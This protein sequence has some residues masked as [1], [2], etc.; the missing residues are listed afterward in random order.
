M[1]TLIKLNGDFMDYKLA[2]V[3]QDIPNTCFN[4]LYGLGFM[5]AG[6]AITYAVDKLA[7]KAFNIQKGS[8]AS[9]AVKAGAFLAGVAV[10]AIA[11]P[12]AGIAAFTGKKVLEMVVLNIVSIAALKFITKEWQPLPFAGGALIGY[13]GPS[14]SL[15]AMSAIGAYAT[16]IIEDKKVNK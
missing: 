7:H 16:F 4:T 5:A 13:A 14:V 6:A 3:P 2:L 8:T 9:K 1:F 11:A 10:C 12:H 15:I